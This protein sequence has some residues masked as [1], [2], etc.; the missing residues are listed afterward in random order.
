MIPTKQQ[1]AEKRGL[2]HHICECGNDVYLKRR[3]EVA[4][5]EML[6]EEIQKD[7]N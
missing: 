4:V 2:H 6:A 5:C 7:D 1:I 3:R